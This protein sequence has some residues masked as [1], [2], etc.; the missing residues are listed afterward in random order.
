MNFN[1]ICED[2]IN[3]NIIRFGNFILSDGSVSEYCFDMKK[4]YSNS[5]LFN[6]IVD[7]MVNRI[8]SHTFDNYDYICGVP[9]GSIPLATAISLQLNKPILYIRKEKKTYG[10]KSQ[11]EGTFNIGD[12]V[13][14]IDDILTTGSSILKT[15]NILINNG[16]LPIGFAV[17]INKQTG[18]FE[19]IKNSDF[20]GVFIYK[21]SGIMNNL[22]SSK[23]ITAFDFNKFESSFMVENTSFQKKMDKIKKNKEYLKKRDFEFNKIQQIIVSLIEDKKTNICLDLTDK[24]SWKDCK[25]LIELLGPYIVL[26]KIDIESLIDFENIKMFVFEIRALIK[27]HKFIVINNCNY[28]ISD[29]NKL[30][31]SYLLY[32]EWATIVTFRSTNNHIELFDKINKH[33]DNKKVEDNLHIS[34]CCLENLNNKP[35]NYESLEFYDLEEYDENSPLILSNNKICKN[36]INIYNIES[37]SI[38]K[39]EDIIIKKQY[40][41]FTVGDHVTKLYN[42]K[43]QTKLLDKIDL[44]ASKGYNFYKKQFNYNIELDLQKEFE[45]LFQI[46][47]IEEEQ[48]DKEELYGKIRKE[49][50][51][52]QESINIKHNEI[53]KNEIELD[54]QKNVFKTYKYL[55]IGSYLFLLKAYYVFHHTDIF[56]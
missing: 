10:N 15:K 14:L 37:D 47:Y 6:E 4:I 7:I 35:F 29:L 52:E 36:R 21:I 34:I 16:L 20:T 3:K 17:C 54:K 8:R 30:T 38:D 32:N 55:F 50:E 56:A 9:F 49:L 11:I 5:D 19:Y 27:K 28:D 41:L 48:L 22:N 24:T 33:N 1:T 45:L 25:N 43:N 40:H 18:S 2:L 23:L 46:N 13:L 42:D 53:I 39:I 12:T 44:F 31:N 51:E 26:L